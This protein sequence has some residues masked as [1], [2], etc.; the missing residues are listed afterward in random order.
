[1]LR[2]IAFGLLL[3]TST[4]CTRLTVLPDSTTPADAPAVASVAE[5]SAEIA[6]CEATGESEKDCYDS[7]FLAPPPPLTVTVTPGDVVDTM[8]TTLHVARHV[9]RD[10]H[11]TRS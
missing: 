1:M 7:H 11:H 4:A 9:A 5:E 8:A 2:S 6:R 10:E 3:L